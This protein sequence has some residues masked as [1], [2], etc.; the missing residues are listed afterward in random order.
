MLQSRDRLWLCTGS[1]S[2]AHLIPVGFVWD[3]EHIMIATREQSVTVANIRSSGTA[4]VAIGEPDDV[5]IIDSTASV[6]GVDDLE[7]EVV[8]AFVRLNHR[9][10]DLPEHVVLRLVPTRILV[11]KDFREHAD[12]VIMRDGIWLG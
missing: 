9:F 5:V 7:P 1:S 4:R 8:D 2:G 6:L 11:W 3:G 10:K 12:R